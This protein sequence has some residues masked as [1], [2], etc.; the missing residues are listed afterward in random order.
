MTQSSPPVVRTRVPLD[1]VRAGITCV[2][3]DG[4]RQLP[5]FTTDI[6]TLLVVYRTVERSLQTTIHGSWLHVETSRHRGTERG[7]RSAVERSSGSGRGHTHCSSRTRH[8]SVARYF[9]VYVGTT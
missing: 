2:R 9:L 3:H 4:A 7:P 8:D 5:A 1:P 6:A